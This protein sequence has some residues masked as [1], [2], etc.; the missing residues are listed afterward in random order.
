MTSVADA[1]YL[2]VHEYPGGAGPLAQRLGMS[3][4]ILRNKVNPNCSTNALSLD[5]A[6]RMMA[7]SG[8]HR[9]LGAITEELRTD[10]SPGDAEVLPL[11]LSKDSAAGRFAQLLAEALEDKRITRNEMLLLSSASNELHETLA[12]LTRRLRCMEAAP[13]AQGDA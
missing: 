1:A 3:A 5:E 10:D 8:D 4:Q 6:V 12:A 9:I 13:P 11:V 2:T 7:L